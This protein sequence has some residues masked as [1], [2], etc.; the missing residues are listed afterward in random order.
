[1]TRIA[2]NSSEVLVNSTRPHDVTSQKTANFESDS[3]SH[4]NKTVF[5]Y[6]SY[7]VSHYFTAR[8]EIV[9]SVSTKNWILC[10]IIWWTSTRLH[11]VISRETPV[12][13]TAHVYCLNS[14]LSSLIINILV[15]LLRTILTY[16]Q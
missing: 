6:P 15:I 16:E 9:T 1:M 10:H 2:T 14:K 11:D 12:F 5:H 4:R 3:K 13:P 8:F 7:I